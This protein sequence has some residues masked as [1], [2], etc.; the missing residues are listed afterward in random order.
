[1]LCERMGRLMFVVL[2]LPE[3]EFERLCVRMGGMVWLVWLAN[4]CT[5]LIVRIKER[6][7]STIGQGIE[8]VRSGGKR[9]MCVES[10]QR[11]K[12]NRTHTKWC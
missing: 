2:V 5:V 4:I 8:D 11:D 7:R 12:S 9:C 3:K 10:D 1:M 6:V